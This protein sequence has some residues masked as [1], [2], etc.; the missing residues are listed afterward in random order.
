MW[1]ALLLFVTEGRLYHPVPLRSVA[2]T[3]YTHVETC[4]LVAFV[5]KQQ[6]G[7]LHVTLIDGTVKVVVELIPAIRLPAPKKGQRMVVRG[8]TRTDREHGYAEIHPA[9]SWE[10]V[11]SCATVR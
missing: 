2:T 4:G 3:R 5:R 9:E 7:D 1:L 11:A 10:A 8:I 6:D